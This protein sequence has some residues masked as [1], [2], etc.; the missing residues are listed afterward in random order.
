MLKGKV[1]LLDFFAVWCGPCIA[2]FPHLREWHDQYADKGLQIIGITNYY[3]YDWDDN[4]D[5]AVRQ[6]ELALEDERAAMDQFSKHY[7][8]PYPIA[9]V[10]GHEL[11]EFYGVSAIPHYVVIDRHGKVRLSRVGVSPRDTADLEQA[12]EE[13]L[14]E[15]ASSE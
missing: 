15:A 10:I 6:E 9:Y 11:Q 4:A 13:C 8:L 12:I 1:V 5:R 2:A 14:A 7:Q 3:K